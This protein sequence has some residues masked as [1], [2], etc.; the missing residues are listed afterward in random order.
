[1]HRIK[2]AAAWSIRTRRR[3]IATA[4][5][6]TTLALIGAG[7]GIAAWITQASHRARLAGQVPSLSLR[8]SW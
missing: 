8:S 6:C 2:R 4:R 3:K 5:T 1:M 7:V